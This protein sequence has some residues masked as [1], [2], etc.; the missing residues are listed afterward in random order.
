[1]RTRVGTLALAA[2]IL[3]P[4]PASGVEG[5]RMKR[6]V[7]DNGLRVILLEKLGLPLVHISAA[8]DVGVKD[9]PPG[10]SGL[11][12]VLE[13]CILFRG[14]ERRSGAEVG[15][16]VR[17]NGAYFNA[18]TGLDTASFEISL[19]AD[20][21]DFGLANQREI[22]FEFDIADDELAREKEV[23]LE[24]IRMIADDPWKRAS[25]LVAAALFPGHPYGRPVFG[26]EADIAALT[27]EA[28]KAFHAAYFVPSNVVLA[29]VGD[30]PLERMEEKVRTAFGPVP[31][32]PAVRSSRPAKAPLL[33]KGQEVRVE[34]DVKEAYLALGFVAADYNHADQYPLDLLVEILGRGINPLLNTALRSRRDLV[35]T[36]TMSYVPLR[37]GGIVMAVLTL[38]PKNIRMA[39]TEAL[40]FLRRARE[41]NFSVDDFS[42]E[43]RTFAYDFLAAAK[44]QVRFSSRRISENGLLLA[45][46]LAR[47]ALMRDGSG[48]DE[49]FQQVIDRVSSSDLR[50]AAARY[51]GK[52][53]SVVVAVVPNP[54]D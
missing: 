9:E 47:H 22:L 31:R 32:G 50:E 3:L 16:D 48:S 49:D 20:R 27:P 39:R 4:S 10:A 14:T 46:A 23:I 53:E 43:E 17:R 52:G 34:M 19:P 40:G 5:P 35:Q 2:A 6:I 25:S 30:L 29:V 15:R 21:A 18:Y 54:K 41:L 13:H 51:F 24:E 12:H 7:L 8:V 38:D 37:A 33:G 1:M 28:I 42:G 44:N 26:E 45:G 36:V 11:V